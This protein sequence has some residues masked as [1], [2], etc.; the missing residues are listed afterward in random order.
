MFFRRCFPEPPS[1]NCWP[2]DG[3]RLF[4]SCWPSY[5]REPVWRD[6]PPSNNALQLAGAQLAS[7]RATAGAVIG[8]R[9]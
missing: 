6:R 2:R 1:G 5:E 7:A 3:G 9:E 8:D 4:R